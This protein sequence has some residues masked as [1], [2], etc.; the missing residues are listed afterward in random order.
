MKKTKPSN[1]FLFTGVLFILC[2][3]FTTAVLPQEN[4]KIVEEVYV[5]NVQVPVRVF[6]GSKSVDGL[7]KSD[8]VLKVNGK[9]QTINGFYSTKKTLKLIETTG[10]ISDAPVQKAAKPRLFV[11]I[12]NITDFKMDF[13]NLLDTLF[14]K[15]IRPNDRVIMITNRFF[16]PEWV[17]TSPEM[18]K[19]KVKE[20][21]K[22]EID[23]LSFEMVR[24]ENEL[25]AL[26]STLLSRM[27]DKQERRFPS[28]IFEDFF[29]NYRYILEDIKEDYLTLPLEQ[30]VKI[31]QYLKGQDLDKWVLN[32][33]EVGR[34]PLLDQFGDVH[35][36]VQAYMDPANVS[37]AGK[38]VPFGQDDTEDPANVRRKLKQYYFDYVVELGKLDDILLKD[39][40]KS[41][42]NSGATFH[43][44]LLKPALRTFSEH[45][46]YQSITSEG[47]VILKEMSRLTGGSI[48]NSNRIDDLLKKAVTRQDVVYVLSYVPEKKE[49]N[50][51]EIS[52]KEKNYRIVFDD[53]R[54]LK[55]FR[56]MV[57]EMRRDKKRLEIDSLKRHGNIVAVKLKNIDLV[58]YEGD[59]YGAVRARIKILDAKSKLIAGFEKTY[60]GINEQGTFKI[61]LPK[62]PKGPCKVVVEVKDLF[63]LNT[64]Y[65]GDAISIK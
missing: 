20:L 16:F 31:A 54:R 2:C 51:L 19:K 9:I 45:Y 11:L 44:L 6:D 13:N 46:K 21:L 23:N 30:Y 55:A 65:V 58:D 18:T 61:T 42:L 50:T 63:S 25:R 33:Y 28:M 47:E 43:T 10:K 39:I 40:N 35:R 52:V 49:K 5:E 15:V 7:K 34:L 48:V 41:F 26:A 36:Q 37:S 3:L 62:L 60:K 64:S 22:K 56:Y 29:L 38:S 17:V 4:E 27:N 12:F 1:F 53:Q 59:S 14:A 32:F 57:K 8:F 24:Y